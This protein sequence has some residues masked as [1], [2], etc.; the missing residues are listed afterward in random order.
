MTRSI[1]IK[2]TAAFW[3]V[4]LIGVASVAYFAANITRNEFD[5]FLDT[6]EREALIA[7]LSTYYADNGSWDGVKRVLEDVST[8]QKGVPDHPFVIVD[9]QQRVVV[10]GMGMR[11]GNR[12]PYSLFRG[13]A[14]IEVNG[15][16]VGVLLSEP[17]SPQWR[18][19][20]LGPQQEFVSRINR[21]MLWAALGATAVSLLIGFLLARSLTRPIKELTTATQA[22]AQGNL[23]QEVPVRS[24]DELGQLA[25]SFN[26][27][28][29]DLSHSQNLRRQM[30]ADIAHDLRTPLSLI[31]GHS[32]ALS[33]GVLPATPETLHIIHDEALR[34][35]R[36]IEDLRTLSLA[37]TGALQINLRSVNPTELLTRTTIAHTP[38]TQDKQINMVVTTPDDLPDVTADSD[39]IVQVLDNLV[40]N[41][42]RYTPQG[43]DIT[44]SACINNGSVQLSVNDSGPGIQTEDLP[45]VFHR[46]YRADKSRQRH[47]GGSGLG[48]AIAKSIIE[49]HNG[50]IWVE[51][52]PGQGTSFTFTLPATAHTKEDK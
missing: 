7:N 4:S 48:L 18:E 31:L 19:R 42:I 46:F 14:P 11:E 5:I 20:F 36:L 9:P 38:A 8:G 33:D 40:H 35:N 28:S 32:E 16:V 25:T 27:M 17:N 21:A 34:L 29:H 2:L 49:Q 26:K 52:P 39:R 13:G 22:V 24:D 44:L 15:E 37:E 10:A 50:R 12:S 45:H 3:I 1:A 47:D 6:Q 30:T 41:A 43:G 23:A 51:S